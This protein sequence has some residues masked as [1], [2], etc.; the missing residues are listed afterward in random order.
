MWRREWT[1][2]DHPF[3]LAPVLGLNT[4]MYGVT[5]KLDIQGTWT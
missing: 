1:P 3:G 4:R 2:L 5:E